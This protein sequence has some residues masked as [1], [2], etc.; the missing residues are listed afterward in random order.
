MASLPWEED[1]P[2]WK[3][4]AGAVGNAILGGGERGGGPTGYQRG[5]DPTM[6]VTQPGMQLPGR[7]PDVMTGY[8]AGF[9][10]D[11]GIPVEAPDTSAEG[12]GGR[13]WD[14][15]KENP[16]AAIEAAGGLYGS[17]QQGQAQDRYAGLQERR[18]DI[19][20]EELDRRARE[21]EEEKERRRRAYQ[22]ILESRDE[23]G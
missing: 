3:K 22:N 8:P 15:I 16:D 1:E 14:W 10:G 5:P 21:R 9:Y 18:V 23:E 13:I 7:Q 2:W 11:S 17:Y 19:E 6:G 4:A 12:V 20:E